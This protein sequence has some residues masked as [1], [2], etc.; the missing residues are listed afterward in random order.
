MT[1]TDSNTCDDCRGS[2]SCGCAAYWNDIKKNNRGDYHDLVSFVLYFFGIATVPP[3]EKHIDNY[4]RTE[5]K[6]E[7]YA[8]IHNTGKIES[9]TTPHEIEPRKGMSNRMAL[10]IVLLALFAILCLGFPW[11]LSQ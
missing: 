8:G 4:M 11:Q 1:Q 5:V 10:L 2:S 6:T 7:S 3:F 9:T